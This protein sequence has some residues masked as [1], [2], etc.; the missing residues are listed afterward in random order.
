M[1]FEK[2]K[3]LI[4]NCG[5]DVHKFGWVSKVTKA[6]GLSKHQIFKYSKTF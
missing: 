5:V 4:L 6:T 3:Q 2:R 1:E